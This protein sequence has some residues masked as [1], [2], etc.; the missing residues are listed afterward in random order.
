MTAAKSAAA[1]LQPERPAGGDCEVLVVGGGPAGAAAA[2]WY[3][4]SGVDVLVVEKKRFPK[5]QD[6]RGRPP[7]RWCTSSNRWALATNLALRSPLS[8]PSCQCVRPR[9]WR[10][11]GPS[12]PSFP[13][14]AMSSPEPTSTGSSRLRPKAGT[15]V[16]QGAEAGRTPV[17][18]GRRRSLHDPT[19]RCDRTMD[20]ARAKTT[21]VTAKYVIVA[22]GSLSRFGR[23][24][25]NRT[26]ARVAP[27]HGATRLLPVA[28]ALRGVHRLVLGHPG[29]RRQGR[30]PA[31][32][33]SSPQ[34]DGHLNVGVRLRSTQGS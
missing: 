14:T 24:A 22:D 7:P 18:P 23:G 26:G 5:G 19:G 13:D 11:T 31:T 28:T 27:G 15:V 16:W 25:R 10:W 2:Y 32:G 29:R 6:V 3:A 4:S 33:G 21:R 30:F 9:W 8:R 34:G 1:Q 20:R 17:C 12:I